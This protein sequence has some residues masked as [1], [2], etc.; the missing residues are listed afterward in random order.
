MPEKG[1][2]MKAAV[3]EAPGSVP[4]CKDV[5][6]PIAPEGWVLAQVQA[7]AIKNIERM[8]AA[9]THYGSSR[10]STPAQLGLDAVALLPDGRRV[11]TGAT[12]PAGAMAEYMPVD[13]AQTV[14]VPQGIDN[15][16][17]AALPNAAISAWF[18]LEY[19]GQIEPGQSVLVLGG[20]GVTGGLAVQLAKHQ[21]GAAHVTVVGRN[22]SRLKELTALGADRVIRIDDDATGLAD[23]VRAVHTEHPF[24]IVLDYLWGTPAENVLRALGNESLTAGFH[25]TRFVQVGETA[26]A[27]IELPAAVL[28]SAGVE[29]IGQGAGSVPKE[30]FGRVPSEILPRLLTLLAEGALSIKTVTRR[31]DDVADAWGEPTG[32]GVR[33]VLVP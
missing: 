33:M 9:G 22:E 31:L 23:A 5:A 6:E 28:R 17:S 13:P 19:A 12:P 27:T 10:M 3:I 25:R 1:A 16:A 7:A 32:S 18:A 21:F 11:Y 2:H 20:T 26:G 8:L 15:A 24:D 29:L 30:A 4:A 14:A